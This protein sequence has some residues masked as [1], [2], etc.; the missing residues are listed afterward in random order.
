M[1]K[2][3]VVAVVALVVAVAG[4]LFPRPIAQVVENLGAS[5]SGSLTTGFQIF[6]GGLAD[7]G[8]IVATSSATNATLDA[9]TLMRASCIDYTLTQAS[10]TLTLPAT[11]TLAGWLPP[12]G[13]RDVCIRN[14]TTTAAIALTIAPGAGMTM[15]N[16]S[17]TLIINGDTDGQNGMWLHMIRN[18]NGNYTVVAERFG[19]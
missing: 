11:S 7:G 8:D 17:S 6:G 16:A 2:T 9:A 15:K 19:D 10:R 5:G 4:V 14:A 12:G 3:L 13:R 18:T 1:N